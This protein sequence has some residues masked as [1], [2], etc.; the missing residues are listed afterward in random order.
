MATLWDSEVPGGL[1]LTQE[2]DRSL[3]GGGEVVG[4]DVDANSG[5]GTGCFNSFTEQDD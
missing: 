1:S 5:T 2:P 4:P 3:C